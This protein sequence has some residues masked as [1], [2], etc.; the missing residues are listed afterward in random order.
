MRSKTPVCEGLGVYL[1]T[2]VPAPNAEDSGRDEIEN[3]P[4]SLCELHVLVRYRP[5]SISQARWVG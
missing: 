2:D 4:D 3:C 1:A 5:L